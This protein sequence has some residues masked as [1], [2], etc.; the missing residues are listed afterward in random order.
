MPNIFHDTSQLE[1][2]RPIG[3]ERGRVAIKRI[4]INAVTLTNMKGVSTAGPG[5]N[6][7]PNDLE[8]LPKRLV[9]AN[10]PLRQP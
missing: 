8:R 9:F 4:S 3:Q 6:Q 5:P 2:A 7:R 10:N 1:G